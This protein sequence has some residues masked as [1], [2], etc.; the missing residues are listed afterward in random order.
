ML[1]FFQECGN[2]RRP[3]EANRFVKPHGGRGGETDLCR[4]RTRLRLLSF[5]SLEENLEPTVIFWYDG[6]PE[7]T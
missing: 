5:P 7:S 2:Q 3:W 1:N 6:R 4:G